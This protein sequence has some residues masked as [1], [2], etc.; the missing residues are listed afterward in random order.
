MDPA[1]VAEIS[2]GL[3][4]FKTLMLLDG[5]PAIVIPILREQS[6]KFSEKKLHGRG[7]ARDI[8]RQGTQN[9]KPYATG[10]AAMERA[11][12]AA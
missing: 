6:L 1:S 10:G 3:L 8:G 7:R 12:E 5:R 2:P 9:R 4:V 11:T